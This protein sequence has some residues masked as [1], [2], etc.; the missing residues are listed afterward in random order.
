M[1]KDD[2]TDQ[3]KKATWELFLQLCQL[4]ILKGDSPQ[5]SVA[6]DE[7]NWQEL[8][9]LSRRHR[10]RPTLYKGINQWEHKDKVPST[11]LT[12]LRSTHLQIVSMNLDHAKELVQQ[13]RDFKKVGIDLIPYKGTI[14]AQEAFGDLGAREMSDIDFLMDIKDFPAIKDYFLARDFIPTKPVPDHFEEKF[15]EQ[16]FEYNFDLFDGKRRIYHVEPHWRIGF[17]RWQTDMNYHDIEP[18]TQ[19]KNVFGVPTKVLTPE[20]LLI[21]TCLHHGGEDRWNTMKDV[22]DITAILLR[23][24]GEMNW[25]QLLIETEKLKV[26]NIVMLGVS[27]ASHFFNIQLP[28]HIQQ[29]IKAPTLQKHTLEIYELLSNGKHSKN[30]SS[31]LESLG[32]HFSLR[33][34]WSTKMKVLYYHLIQIFVPTIY[35]VNDKK[36]SGMKY[37][38]L[39]LTKPFRIWNLH[40]R[41]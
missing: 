27:I 28:P 25:E 3:D 20:G 41:K 34:H 2:M 5:P 10:V 7:V 4:G 9:R 8:S 23:F 38:M 17:K 1:L 37:W 40:I 30:I 15:F 33:V 22:I 21:T 31:F 13:I 14:L 18:L 16:N 29:Y 35:D 39:F 24:K 19:I 12:E 36:T 32:Y 6:Y 11:L 26:T